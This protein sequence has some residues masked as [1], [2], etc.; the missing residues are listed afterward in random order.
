MPEGQESLDLWVP[1][2]VTMGGAAISQD[3]AMALLVDRSLSRGL[4]PRGSTEG[5][6]GRTYHY[7]QGPP[8]VQG[9]PAPGAPWVI[10]RDIQAGRAYDV[11][12]EHREGGSSTVLAVDARVTVASVD[13]DAV[14]LDVLAARGTRSS[15]PE[16][17]FAD[18]R[19]KLSVPMRA[20]ATF[21]G[22]HTAN[23]DAP[24][25][26]EFLEPRPDE[27]TRATVA[28]L[29]N[30]LGFKACL[31]PREPHKTG[32]KWTETVSTWFV[33]DVAIA[34]EAGPVMVHAGGAFAFYDAVWRVATAKGAPA[35]FQAYEVS[36]SVRMNDGFAGE[37]DVKDF[38]FGPDAPPQIDHITSTRIDG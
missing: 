37:C 8:K 32:D 20:G 23:D 9:V 16:P 22:S 24:S 33:H 18:V 27:G 2:E 31:L 36:L 29:F 28:A 34:W 17:L 3:V 13:A 25:G 6:G 11:R 38:T 1:D 14:V 5:T 21:P 4:F 35:T 15:S 12:A 7:R 30:T 26:F 10:P 19:F